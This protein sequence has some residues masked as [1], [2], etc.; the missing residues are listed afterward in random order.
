MLV[1]CTLDTAN[2]NRG[3]AILQNGYTRRTP[4]EAV[5]SAAYVVAVF[6]LANMPAVAQSTIDTQLQVT[7]TPIVATSGV[8]K[9]S[10]NITGNVDRT[11]AMMIVVSRMHPNSAY[12]RETG[13]YWP[14]NR[15]DMTG[16]PKGLRGIAFWNYV[17]QV[18]ERMVRARH[19]STAFLKSCWIPAIRT[20][21]PMLAPSLK[22]RVAAYRSEIA[23]ARPGG[24]ART[25]PDAGWA[26]PARAGSTLAMAEI[27]NAA[28][29][30]GRNAVLDE[31][32]NEAL[33]AVTPP[34]LQRQIDNEARRVM[35][36]VSQQQLKLDSAKLAALGLYV[37]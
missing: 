10:T 11:R 29:V 5:N 37:T 13:N 33:W 34:I 31:K 6:T 8:K 23:N 18:A 26:K 27:A 7:T 1:K 12:S 32:H 21:E 20:L 9:G 16:V 22:A 4:A 15:P 14:V 3:L 19:S 28:G 25:V 30:G 2:L 35:E 36:L 24:S 17:E